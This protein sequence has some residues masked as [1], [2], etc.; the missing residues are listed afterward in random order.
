MVNLL[1]HNRNIR[2]EVSFAIF[3]VRLVR[4]SPGIPETNIFKFSK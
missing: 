3:K 4:V 1:T 2:K